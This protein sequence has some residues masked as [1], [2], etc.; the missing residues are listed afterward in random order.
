MS[1]R[2]RRWRR[3]DYWLR[4]VD[5]GHGGGW[6]WSWNGHIGDHVESSCALK[7]LIAT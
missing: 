1:C 3:G 4:L 6:L 2:I 5:D 7:G